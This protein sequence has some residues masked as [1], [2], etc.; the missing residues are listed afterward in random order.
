MYY[1]LHALAAVVGRLSSSSL[2]RLAWILASLG[3]D[4]LRLR[5]RTVLNNLQIAFPDMSVQQRV[6]LGRLSLYHFVLT[7]LEFL[8][9]ARTDIAADIEVLGLEHMQQALAQGQGAY[10]LCFHLGN[11][12]AMGSRYTRLIGPSYILVKKVGSGGVERFVNELRE[13]NDF[14]WV[15][16]EKKGD[17]AK[18]IKD[19]LGRGEVVGF[20]IDQ[21]R[22]GE[23]KL[24]FFGHPAKT[25]TSLAAL[26]HKYPAPIVPSYI[27]RKGASRHVLNILAPLSLVSSGDEAADILTHSTLFNSVVEECVRRHP[28][29]YFWMHNRW[30]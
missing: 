18:A 29:Q 19:I 26:W 27:I 22:P 21:S 3:F 14:L 17:G 16:R 5:R 11:W 30:K 15:K 7:G 25:N 9:S 28:E 6:R 13:K 10:V 2:E 8:R 23:P 20:V 1:L 24:P 12:E 4:V